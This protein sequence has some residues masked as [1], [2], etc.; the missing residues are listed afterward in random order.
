MN[1]NDVKDGLWKA[2]VYGLDGNHTT[3]QLMRLVPSVPR[4]APHHRVNDKNNTLSCNFRLLF[5]GLKRFG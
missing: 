5:M 1:Q 2:I 4:Y 3:M